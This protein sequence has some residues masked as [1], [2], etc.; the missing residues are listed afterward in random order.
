[1][2]DQLHVVSGATGKIGHELAHALL[3][4]GKRVRV[5][6]R[7]AGKLKVFKGAET[8][9]GSLDDAMYLK[10]ALS[11]ATAVF[12]MIP[13]NLATSDY[14]GYCRRIADSYLQAIPA[15]G[16]THVVALS[17]I[18]GHLAEGAGPV[19]ALHEMEER[20]GALAANVLFLRPGYFLENNLASVGM[21]KAMNF[22]GS[23]LRP[24]VKIPMIATKDIAAVAAKRLQALDFTG[25]S[26]LELHGAKDYTMADVART[27]GKEINKPDL[28]YVQFPYED[29]QKGMEGMGI[30]ADVARLFIEM[31]KGF[32][33]GLIAPTQKRSAETTTPTTLGQFAKQFA[34]A[35][36][37]AGT[38]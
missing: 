9:I 1:M 31:N 34:A 37:A 14:R 16:A 8:A 32:N 33:D 22:L 29:A 18:G 30:S 6:G 36:R 25:K 4:A 19:S 7:D 21:V 10:K 12:A 35:Y 38:R 5:L 15:S 11:G 2:P 24:D 13:P 23:P 26:V 28:T 3:A 17:S 27:L 20:F